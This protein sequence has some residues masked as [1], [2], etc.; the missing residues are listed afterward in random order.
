ML[1]NL[2]TLKMYNSSNWKGITDVGM[3]ELAKLNKLEFL[4]LNFFKRITNDGITEIN[5]LKNL[6]ELRILFPPFFV[7]PHFYTGK[8]S[9]T[10]FIYKIK[11]R[12]KL[13]TSF[14]LTRYE[15]STHGE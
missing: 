4:Q 9:G 15:R 3:R 13:K 2:R 10:D 8:T 11:N 12:T 6:Q 7:P 5:Q 14:I 1:S